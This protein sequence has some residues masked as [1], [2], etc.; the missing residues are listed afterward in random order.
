MRNLG[1]GTIDLTSIPSGS[2]VEA[3]YL[4]WDVLDD[5]QATADAQGEFDGTDITGNLVGTGDSPCWPV[6][7]NY[8]FEAD[9]SNLVSG[10]GPYSLSGFSTGVSNGEDPWN[11]SSPVPELEG[12]SLVVVYGNETEPQTYVDLSAGSTETDSGNSLQQQ[13]SGFSVSDPSNA[14]T[15][16]IVAD[17]QGLGSTG[18][19]NGSTE[20]PDFLGGDPQAAPDYSQGNLW[21]TDTVDVSDVITAGD[22]SITAGVTGGGDCVVWVGQ[23][24]SV[25][26]SPEPVTGYKT[27]GQSANQTSPA[28]SHFLLNPVQSGGANTVSL[29]VGDQEQ[30]IHGLGATLTNSSAAVLESLPSPELDSALNSLFNPVSGAGISLIRL[31]MGANDFSAFGCEPS[32]STCSKGDYTYDDGP[33]GSTTYKDPSLANFSI[34]PYDSDIV[35]I[36]QQALSINPNLTIIASPWTAPPWM[37]TS[38]SFTG[39]GGNAL[40]SNYY[41]TYANYF[42]DYIKA[43]ASQG[44]SI[45]YVTPQNEPGAPA[46]N[47]PGMVWTP[48]HETDFV[49]NNLAPDLVGLPTKILDYDWN[50]NNVSGC[51]ASSSSCWNTSELSQLLASAPAN[52]VGLAW[53]CYTAPTGSGAAQTA[54]LGYLNFLTECTGSKANG[55]NFAFNLNWDAQHLLAGTLQ[56][57]GSGVQFFNLALNDNDGP[58]SGGGCDNKCRG[59][60]TIDPDNGDVTNNVEYWLLTEAARAFSPGAHLISNSASIKKCASGKALCVISAINPDTSTGVLVSNPTSS[61]LPLTIDDSGVGFSDEIPK[62]AV[63]SFRWSQPS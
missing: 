40:K 5:S 44:I 27:T 36:L 24:T 26:A 19:F 35:Q 3:A 14:A 57:G 46:S 10:N 15:T 7:A 1:Y 2:T 53:H 13:L 18:T 43:Y 41:E 63:V 4:L 29:N 30:T 11:F 54:F 48:A 50:W 52:V 58:Q 49:D 51:S 60:V 34:F 20:V 21:D 16:F 45:D 59:V 23:A 9:V 62:G 56:N 47:Y 39:S 32:A 12:A 17:G 31:S 33:S 61:S 22:T 38:R 55:P 6:S 37:K 8:S 28:V 25:A 42:V